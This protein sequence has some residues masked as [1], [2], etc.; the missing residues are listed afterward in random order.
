MKSSG[1]VA[2]LITLSSSSALAEII[3]LQGNGISFR[4][5]A[6]YPVAFPTT[7]VSMSTIVITQPLML[8]SPMVQRAHAWSAYQK[9]N[10]ASG[11]GLI[12]QPYT[13]TESEAQMSLNRNMS[14]AHAYR[15]GY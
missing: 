14:R 12:L 15:L 4:Y 7:G 1:L 9:N 10:N 8:G 11:T 5:G 13:G 6:T 2:L 3:I